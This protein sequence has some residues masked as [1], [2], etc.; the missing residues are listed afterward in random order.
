MN[1][2]GHALRV[3]TLDCCLARSGSATPRL[4]THS[5]RRSKVACAQEDSGWVVEGYGHVYEDAFSAG[6]MSHAQL[7]RERGVSFRQ[8]QASVLEVGVHQ[9]TWLQR[10]YAARAHGSTRRMPSRR[11]E[12]DVWRRQP[13][14]S[15]SQV[16]AGNLR[17]KQVPNSCHCSHLQSSC[18]T[19]TVKGCS[20][21]IFAHLCISVGARQQVAQVV[22]RFDVL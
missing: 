22:E 15:E 9:L 11:C 5:I 18:S 10:H 17:S 2:R 3:L 12:T 6:A 1:T 8:L 14:Y 21:N 13:V 19:V 16:T 20:R 4:H 7:R